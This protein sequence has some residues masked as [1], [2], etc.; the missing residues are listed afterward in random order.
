MH[1][2][3]HTL[4]YDITVVEDFESDIGGDKNTYAFIKSK[5]VIIIIIIIIYVYTYIFSH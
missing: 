4:I 1:C 3:E 5:N 2:Y